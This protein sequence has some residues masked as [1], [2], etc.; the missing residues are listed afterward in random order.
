MFSQKSRVLDYVMM[1]FVVLSF[2]FKT[3]EMCFTSKSSS[4]SAQGE[5]KVGVSGNS[6]LVRLVVVAFEI[7]LPSSLALS[8]SVFAAVF[9]C[10]PMLS[11][12]L[13]RSK[14]AMQ[15]NNCAALFAASGRSGF[16]FHIVTR[17]YLFAWW[18]PRGET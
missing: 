18:G 14:R 1:F 11:C 7:V 5:L 3:S 16:H 4:P 17:T 15:R 13:T 12:D 10:V 9:P 8:R 6:L 2:H